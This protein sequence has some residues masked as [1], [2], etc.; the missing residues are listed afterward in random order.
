MEATLRKIRPHLFMISVVLLLVLL[1][2]M[3]KGESVRIRFGHAETLE[4]G[5]TH[6]ETGHAIPTLP[7]DLDVDK[8]ETY[9]VLTVLDARFAD[10]QIMLVRASLSDVVVRLDGEILQSKVNTSSFPLDLYASTWMLVDIPAGSQGKTL[11]IA[12]TSPYAAFSGRV[13]LIHVGTDAEVCNH[14]LTGYLPRFVSGLIIL[15][16]G[17]SLLVINLAADRSHNSGNAY[18]GVFAVFLSLWIFGESRM[19]QFITGS[20]FI[21]GGMTYMMVA[22][23]PVPLT[24]YVKRSVM[25]RHKKIFGYA[26]T[27]YGI[28][29]VLVFLLQAR[30][31]MDFFESVVISQVLILLGLVLLLVTLVFEKRIDPKSELVRQAKYYLILVVFGFFELVTYFTG[32]FDNTSVYLLMGFVLFLSIQLGNYIRQIVSALRKASQAEVYERLAYTD[33]LTGALNRAAYEEAFDRIFA[34]TR[35]RQAIRLAF[36]DFDDLK[37]IND[38]YG[39]LEGDDVLK[40]GYQAIEEA[41]SSQGTCYRIG[42]DEFACILKGTDGTRY[43]EMLHAFNALIGSI[44][45]TRGYPIKVSVGYAV[46]DR[47]S[48]LK[49]SDM[50]KRADADM[51]R[52]KHHTKTV[53]HV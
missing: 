5:W 26:A 22:I 40:E 38:T 7:A 36:F 6:V 37:H 31:T 42:G 4:N 32:N 49:P 25:D 16:I 17:I 10:A 43:G 19:V 1:G 11:E 29:A 47:T 14:I 52:N 44:C 2:W 21:N 53:E 35:S 18:L 9:T 30:G 34:D 33:R 39:H 20:V 41:F 13:N 45:D 23:M 46:Y 48:D 50:M 24:L 15:I 51:Y 12:M 3:F 28:N 27:V 8:G